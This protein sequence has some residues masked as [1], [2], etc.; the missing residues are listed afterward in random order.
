MKRVLAILAVSILPAATAGAV[1]PGRVMGEIPAPGRNV[2]GLTYGKGLVWAADHRTDTIVGIDASGKVV[3]SFK[4]PGYRPAGLAFDGRQLWNVD[5]LQARLFRIDPDSGLVTRSVPSPVQRPRC[6]A[7]DGKALWLSDDAGRTIHRVDPEDGTTIREVPFPSKSVDGL[8]WDGRYLWIADRLADKLLVMDTDH[9]EVLFSVNAPGPH[10]SGLAFD[11]RMLRVADYQTDRIAS[12]AR[13]GDEFLLVE[14]EKKLWVTFTHQLRNFGPDELVDVEVMLAVPHDSGYQAIGQLRF[15][16][17]PAEY[18]VDRWGQ[19]VAVFRFPRLAAPGKTE[20][21]M[22]ARVQTQ[23][24]WFLFYPEQ[25]KPLSRIPRSIRQR[26]LVDEPKYDIRNPV[27]RR[28]VAEAVG[29]ERNPYWIVRGILRH[30]HRRM[31]YERIGGWDV[32]PKVLE[33]GS[34][35]CSEYSYVMISMCRAAGVPARYV[36]SLVVRKDKAS[37]DDVFHRWVEVYLPGIGWVPVDPS[38]GDKPTEAERAD[39]FGK[40]TA[41]FLVTTEG[42]GGSEFLGWNYNY[43]ERYKCRGRCRVEVEPIAEWSPEPPG[44]SGK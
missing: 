25:V 28:A 26:Y 7:W 4:S 12:V 44:K 18:R 21:D 31:H 24:M 41:D 38:R 33:R 40:V 11:G 14:K 16:P 1:L 8:A 19:K 17:E 13:N 9:G 42:G 2:T 29:R 6:L 15:E 34:G 32:A 35:S 10:A 20:I 30:I 22:I 5:V 37:Y 36:G 39:S 43:N 23:R 3:R 27:I